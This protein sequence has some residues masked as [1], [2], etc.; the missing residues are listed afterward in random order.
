MNWPQEPASL[1]IT[2]PALKNASSFREIS[3]ISQG[4]FM[5]GIFTTLSRH[6]LHQRLRLAGRRRFSI[7]AIPP[8]SQTLRNA[9][10]VPSLFLNRFA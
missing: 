9:R 1:D 5:R 7:N 8:D 3:T 10:G 6:G 2:T 4:F